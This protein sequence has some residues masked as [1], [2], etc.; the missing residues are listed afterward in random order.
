MHNHNL[1]IVQTFGQEN[2]L[3]P[4]YF[5]P[6]IDFFFV[7]NQYFIIDEPIIDEDDDNHDSVTIINRS[8]GLEEASFVI[9]EQFHRIE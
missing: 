5:S 7:S 4:F 6:G 1:E 8:N 2:P 3:L 9:Y